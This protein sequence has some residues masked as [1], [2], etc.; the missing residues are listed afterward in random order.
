M[1]ARQVAKPKI[2]DANAN[3]MFDAITNGFEYTAN[4]AIDSLSKNN[5]QADGRHGV[6]SRN[7]CLLTVEINS[8]QQFRCQFGVPPA[9]QCHFVF[10]LNF[11]AW[12]R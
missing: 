8:A 9:I 6:E 11:V 1:T 3:E 4:L 10:L 7:P 12:M 5:A 2:S